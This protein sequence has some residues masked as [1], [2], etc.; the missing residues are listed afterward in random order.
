[1]NSETTQ[2]KNVWGII[3]QAIIALL[4]ALSGIFTGCQLAVG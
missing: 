1:M 2:K 3:V 4:T